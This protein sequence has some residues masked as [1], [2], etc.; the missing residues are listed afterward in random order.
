VLDSRSL[1][2]VEKQLERIC[3]VNSIITF[4]FKIIKKIYA[5]ICKS[6]DNI[7]C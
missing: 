5:M 6:V 3:S 7:Y 2:C 4:N 1:E